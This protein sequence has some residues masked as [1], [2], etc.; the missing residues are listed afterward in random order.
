MY[1]GT[2]PNASTFDRLA[3]EK[4]DAAISDKD[5]KYPEVLQSSNPLSLYCLIGRHFQTMPLD[6]MPLDRIFR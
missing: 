5:S 4:I 1:S 3:D 2:L 6:C